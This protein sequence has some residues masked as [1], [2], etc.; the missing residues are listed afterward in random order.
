MTFA[1][2]LAIGGYKPVC[3][4]LLHFPATRC[5]QVLRQAWRLKSFRVLFAVDRA[6]IVGAERS[7]PSGCF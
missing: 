3:R 2:G 1:A 6:G 4:D 7:N 5:D